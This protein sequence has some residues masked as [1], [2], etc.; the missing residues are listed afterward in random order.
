M[1][2]ETFKEITAYHPEEEED[3]DFEIFE[4]EIIDRIQEVKKS[5]EKIGF[6][7]TAEVFVCKT[8][9][10][11]CYKVIKK[12]LNPN[13]FR[14]NVKQEGEFLSDVRS[15]DNEIMVPTPYYSI[16]AQDGI[17]VLVM[18]RLRA[19][20]INELID[21]ELP[22]PEGFD[23][24]SFFKKISSFFQKMHENKKIFHRDA[25]GGNLMVELETGK[26]CIIDFGASKRSYLSSENPYKETTAK[27][28]TFIYTPDEERLRGVKS[29]LRNYIIKRMKEAGN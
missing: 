1:L 2:K 21:D 19:V 28:E 24:N 3:F 14:V 23:L 4:K 5:G 29:Q 12:D 8:N 9:E 11:I 6:G 26:P 25:H 17:E 15:L 22:L 20:S 7:E 27:R 13:K 16:I 10:N 18:K